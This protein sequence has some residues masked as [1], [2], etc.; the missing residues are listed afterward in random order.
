ME[1]PS[2]NPLY[3]ETAGGTESAPPSDTEELLPHFLRDF[4]ASS[5]L[6]AIV[7]VASYIFKS[8][9]LTSCLFAASFHLATR[10][11]KKLF[12]E[13]SFMKSLEEL[14]LTLLRKAPY[15]YVIAAI[16]ALLFVWFAP[17][18]SWITAACIGILS[19]L[20]IEVHSDREHNRQLA[21]AG[22]I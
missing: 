1:A 12:N 3:W 5:V 19:G 15:I 16:V 21:A 18:V 22:R 6:T 9:L 2:F 17:L 13:F 8:P 20:T 4:R 11:I 14:S 7:F 10:L